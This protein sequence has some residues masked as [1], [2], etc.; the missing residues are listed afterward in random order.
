M[1]NDYGNDCY[2]FLYTEINRFDHESYRIHDF[3]TYTTIT[4]CYR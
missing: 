4:D 1:R 3:M 2:N